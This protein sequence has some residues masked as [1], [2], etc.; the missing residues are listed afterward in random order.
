MSFHPLLML[1]AGIAAGIL[2]G[3]IYR[4]IT[5]NRK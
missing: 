2:A 4:F 1:A 5:G 3:L